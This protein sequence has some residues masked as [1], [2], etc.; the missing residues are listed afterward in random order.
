[1]D[2]WMKWRLD[3]MDICWCVMFHCGKQICDLSHGVA[4]KELYAPWS[5]A[6]MKQTMD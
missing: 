4:I 1:M 2:V 3:T 6:R 5:N